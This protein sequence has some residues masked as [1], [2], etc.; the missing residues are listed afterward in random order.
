[1]KKTI[2]AAMVSTAIL[3]GCGKT[4]TDAQGQAAAT[5]QQ[6]T[7]AITGIR[8]D[9]V[10]EIDTQYAN[11][12]LRPYMLMVARDLQGMFD[13]DFNDPVATDKAIA[14]YV[15]SASCVLEE[16]ME[17]DSQESPVFISQFLLDVTFNTP[18]REL[19]KEKLSKSADLRTYEHNA[20]HCQAQ[21][22]SM[23]L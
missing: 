10:E 3:L 5:S 4:E 20:S 12:S 15:G 17:R 8:P 21:K 11:S 22:Q 6:A 19:V 2:L 16:M 23:V 18:E 13:L 1:M 9:V 7:K 14:S